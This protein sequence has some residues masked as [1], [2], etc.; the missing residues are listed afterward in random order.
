MSWPWRGQQFR[1]RLRGEQQLLDVGRRPPF[2]SPPLIN[3]NE[4]RGL[5]A[6]LG[7]DLR[8]FG[9]ARF[10]K[11]AEAGLGLLHLPCSTHTSS[12]GPVDD[13]L[14]DQYPLRFRE[15]SRCVHRSAATQTGQRAVDPATDTVV[16]SRR[17]IGL[18]LEVSVDYEL[19]HCR[20]IK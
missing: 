10:E 15:G 7:Y 12:A 20:V 17:H 5:Y 14:S 6:S 1:T 9:E 3:R 8:P 13:Y 4:Y 2:Q 16:N 11:L 18:D 19:P